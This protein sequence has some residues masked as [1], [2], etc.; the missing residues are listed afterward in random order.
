MPEMPTDPKEFV[1]YVTEHIKKRQPKLN[2]EILNSDDV[3]VDGRRLDLENLKRMVD[4]EPARGTDIV[5]EFLDKLFLN[6]YER[7]CG[8]QS[9]D[10]IK[11][12]IMPRIQPI[13]IFEHFTEEMVAHVPYVN[14]TVIVFVI[15]MPQ[16]TVNITTEQLVKWGVSIDEIHEIALKNLGEYVP[17]LEMKIIESAEG[18]KAVI[19]EK[20]DGYDA[21][22]LCLSGLYNELAP[23]LGETFYVVTP[24]RD[25][26][27]A[28]SIEPGEFVDRVRERISK[29]FLRLPY[30]ITKELFLVTQDG[31]AGTMG[32]PVVPG[33][34]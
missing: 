29:D 18:G 11:G 6:D 24:A 8:D 31:V 5:A 28:C 27:I 30:P 32:D 13:S 14:D 20:R 26:F 10:E 33:M 16:M 19:L 9:F 1:E 34:R 3:L 4:F 25:I 2:I 23:D 7:K 17:D 21:A 12:Q 15:D 22:R